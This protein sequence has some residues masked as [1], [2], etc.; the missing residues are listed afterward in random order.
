MNLQSLLAFINRKADPR[1]F[2]DEIPPVKRVLASSERILVEQFSSE[3]S[4]PPEGDQPKSATVLMR[5]A[6]LKRIHGRENQ[7]RTL[8]ISCRTAGLSSDWRVSMQ[9]SGQ[10]LLDV[11]GEPLEM[12]ALYKKLFKS[13]ELGAKEMFQPVS[14]FKAWSGPAALALILV[15]LVF[16]GIGSAAPQQAPIGLPSLPP[17]PLMV[18]Q[19]NVQ[20]PLPSPLAS[21]AA[22]DPTADSYLTGVEKEKVLANKNRVILSSKGPGLVVFSDPNCPFCKK[23]ESSLEATV[24]DAAISIIPVGF[25]PG[26]REAIASILCS[27]DVPSA[28]RAAVESGK[29]AGPVCD[30]GLKKVDEN[31]KLFADLRLSVTPTIVSPKGLLVPTY[32][33]TEQLA[34]VLKN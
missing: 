20:D 28:W 2:F 23:L 9:S 12:I 1:R 22:A 21:Q 6:R 15:Y 14:R 13:L 31:N 25:K 30:S 10:S 27:K 24:K 4:P 17:P 11:G 16:V 33:T 18:P 19:G 5:E 32:T 26:S 8:R 29:A 3:I 7:E 34:L